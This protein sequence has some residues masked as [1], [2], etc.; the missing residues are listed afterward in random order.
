MVYGIFQYGTL[1]GMVE[2]VHV[3]IPLQ[4]EVLP[5]NETTEWILSQSLSIRLI[6]VPEKVL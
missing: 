3:G 1:V 5:L 4:L 2:T 6:R